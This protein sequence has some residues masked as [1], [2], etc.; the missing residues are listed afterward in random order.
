MSD[1]TQTNIADPMDAGFD[2]HEPN[3]KVIALLGIGTVIALVAVILGLQ[4]Y[5]DS[6]REQQ[7]YVKVLEPLADDL[8]ALRARED[9]QLHSYQYIDREQGTVRLTIERAM[10]LLVKEAAEGKLKY[11]TTPYPVK[12]EETQGD[13]TTGGAQP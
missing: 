12:K 13:A 1:E 10:T 6:A 4:Y 8:L 11:P 5:Y 2:R 7:V 3:S 9:E